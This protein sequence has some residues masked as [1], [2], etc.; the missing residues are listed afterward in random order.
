MG[1]VTPLRRLTDRP[2][3]PPA[4]PTN[5]TLVA[6]ARDGEAGA[7]E[8]LLGH[9]SFTGSL[10]HGS[11]WCHGQLACAGRNV[12]GQ[13]G[14]D[15][16]V[17]QSDPAFVAGSDWVSL[18]TGSG[19]RALRAALRAWPRRHAPV[20]IGGKAQASASRIHFRVT[21]IACDD[22]SKYE[23]QVQKSASRSRFCPHPVW[24]EA[25]EGNRS[26]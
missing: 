21:I 23:W 26:I 4:G 3:S 17:E 5:A 16:L 20:T 2:S 1:T 11:L 13:L 6:S 12:E 25:A 19:S 14:N 22:R 18:T 9:G 7:L 10:V 8:A 15:D 24:V